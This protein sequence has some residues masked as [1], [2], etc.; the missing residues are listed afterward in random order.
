[1]DH[2]LTF[3]EFLECIAAD[4]SGLADSRQ[5]EIA[6]IFKDSADELYEAYTKKC[7]VRRTKEG[8]SVETNQIVNLIQLLIFEYCRLKKEN[9]LIKQCANCAMSLS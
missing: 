4:A 1:M 5:E 9:K 6:K 2:V 3:I 8:V 7:S